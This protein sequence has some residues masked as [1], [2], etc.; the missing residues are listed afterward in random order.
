[1]D[2]ENNVRKGEVLNVAVVRQRT[3]GGGIRW[4]SEIT[5]GRGRY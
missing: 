5:Y 4:S 3:E 2:S 1:M